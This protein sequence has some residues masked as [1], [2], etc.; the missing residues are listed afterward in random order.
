MIHLIVFTVAMAVTRVSGHGYLLVPPA[1]NTAWRTD[2]EN[3]EPNY[4]DTQL[5]CG[6]FAVSF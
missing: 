4:T 1:R 3:W 5:N 6:G 2:P